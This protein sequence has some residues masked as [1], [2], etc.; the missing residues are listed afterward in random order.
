MTPETALNP[1]LRHPWLSLKSQDTTEESQR[2]RNTALGGAAGATVGLAASYAAAQLLRH[3]YPHTALGAVATQRPQAFL[4]TSMPAGFAL[5]AS[6]PWIKTVSERVQAHDDAVRQ[7]EAQH[8]TRL[9][10]SV[11]HP[12]ALAAAP[13]LAG[14]AL[15]AAISGPSTVGRLI[16]AGAGGTLGLLVGTPMMANHGASAREAFFD[17][18]KQAS[19]INPILL[20]PTLVKRPKTPAEAEERGKHFASYAAGGAALGA[21]GGGLLAFK[22]IPNASEWAVH[23]G[24]LSLGA[25]A[26]GAMS[27]SMLGLAAG[28]VPRYLKAIQEHDTAAREYETRTGDHLSFPVRHPH[29]LVWGPIAAGAALGA[30]FAPG[31]DLAMRSVGGL[32]G[33]AAAG[34]SASQLAAAYAYKQRKDK[35]GG[36]V[37]P[38]SLQDYGPDFESDHQTLEQRR[39][40]QAEL[41]GQM[42]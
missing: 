41:E 14:A 17:H 27:G 11:R 32:L 9:P 21:L 39:Q 28:Y 5:G 6:V 36:R 8:Q 3:K 23:R 35:F 24:P 13:P 26:L 15:G 16:G 31:P 4:E 37:G 40:L 12:F 1:A 33:A 34:L 30:K 19:D 29:A 10:V 18:P 42:V 7:Y 38:L 2:L 25:A 20:H 22:K